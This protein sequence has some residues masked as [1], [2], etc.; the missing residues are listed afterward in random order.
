MGMES[1]SNLDRLVTKYFPQGRL[2]RAWALE[3][4]IS[5]EMTALEI[6][7]ADGEISRWIV[8]R[9]LGPVPR[10]NSRSIEDEFRL[11]EILHSLG[12]AAP[13]PFALDQSGEVFTE[14]YM[15]MAYI[16][17]RPDFAPANPEEYAVQMAEELGRIHAVDG[18][19]ADLSFLPRL[20]EGR[21]LQQRPAQMD[22]SL[23]EERIRDTLEAA[24]PFPQYNALAL[25]HGDYWPGNILWQEA[26]LAAVIDWE[27]A[28]L[29]DPLA[30]L[31]IS[32]LDLLWIY[33][34]G[35][36][37]AFTRHYLARTA[38]DTRSLPYWDLYAALRLVRLAGADMQEWAAFFEP[39][40]RGDI[41]E[42]SIR[43][44]YRFFV[45]QAL[46][47]LVVK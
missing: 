30:D 7:A 34:R 44:Y 25:L 4:G 5:A 2:L 15:L 17:G 12:L 24:W 28:A 16:E 18:S 35:A 37:E 27:D 9:S 22:D 45:A 31:A 43:S 42:Q 36:M 20:D 46:E 19:R 8:R 40:D 29:G 11:L 3:G 6:A 38:I 26:R 39:Y 1:Y 10:R 41:T 13:A 14:S 33:G 32:R 23:D 21:V 47:K